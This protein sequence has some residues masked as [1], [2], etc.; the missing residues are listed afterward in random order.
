MN[1]DVINSLELCRLNPNFTT[2]DYAF[3]LRHMTHL[4]IKYLELSGN[5]SMSAEILME[6][7]EG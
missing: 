1:S 3:I 4:P 2:A 7:L 5:E 6:W